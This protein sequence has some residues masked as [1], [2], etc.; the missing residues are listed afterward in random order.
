MSS[1]DKS[2]KF[3]LAHQSELVEKY[4]GKIVVIEEENILD[5]FDSFEAA[6]AWAD[7]KRLLG[8]VLIQD[9]APGE[10]NYT[11]TFS[12]VMVS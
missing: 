7:S 11:H 1:L 12:N 9:V 2:F 4:N 10:E 5:S 3:Y 8:K 6:Y